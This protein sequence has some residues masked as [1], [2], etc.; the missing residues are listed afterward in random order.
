M[1]YT[2]LNCESNDKVA[3]KEKETFCWENKDKPVEGNDW[4]KPMDLFNF[5]SYPIVRGKTYIG[6]RNYIS[7]V[8]CNK[9]LKDCSK[10]LD[11][12][13]PVLD[14]LYY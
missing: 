2:R 1:E 10:T 6:K 12:A 8:L 4:D 13:N 9:I 7:R 11:L 3:Q 14:S 5:V